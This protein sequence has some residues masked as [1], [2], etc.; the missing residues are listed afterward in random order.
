M[1]QLGIPQTSVI[2]DPNREAKLEAS[3]EETAEITAKLAV[4]TKIIPASIPRN[5][6]IFF[7]GVK[8]TPTGDTKITPGTAGNFAPAPIGYLDP[9]A[10]GLRRTFYLPPG[11]TDFLPRRLGH[12]GLGLP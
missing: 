4:L 3:A 5:I 11:S 6:L 12:F 9:T 1:E 7:A 2:G 10:V 8:K